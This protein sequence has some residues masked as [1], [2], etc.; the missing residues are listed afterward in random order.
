MDSP[1]NKDIDTEQCCWICLDVDSDEQ[2][3]IK[4]C[5]CV[6]YVHAKCMARWQLTR[7]GTPEE[8][9]CR[10]CKDDL[11]DWRQPLTPSHIRVAPRSRVTLQCGKTKFIINCHYSTENSHTP[12]WGSMK[13]FI[14]EIESRGID[15]D[16][17]SKV[18]FICQYPD[19]G[20]NFVLHGFKTF[21]A[22]SYCAA[23]SAAKRELLMREKQKE[24]HHLNKWNRLFKVFHCGSLWPRSNTNV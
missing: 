21:H 18:S 10:F 19:T 4:S 15:V 5:S 17:N 6:R 2:P 20:E 9:N 14:K 23:I 8:T 1:H 12:P 3:L 7:A 16:E 11:E 13:Q 24:I 22:A